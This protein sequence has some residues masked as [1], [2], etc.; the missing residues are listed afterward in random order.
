MK[1]IYI[2]TYSYYDLSNTTIINCVEL[3][4]KIVK[5]DMICHNCI[6]NKPIMLCIGLAQYPVI[7]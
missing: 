6:H 3:F 2:L 5:S 7:S 4:F 1:E